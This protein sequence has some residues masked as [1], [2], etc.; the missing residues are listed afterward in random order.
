MVAGVRTERSPLERPADTGR[1]NQPPP[2]LRRS[3]E[4]LG[5]KAEGLRYVGP[6]PS[7]F[8]MAPVYNLLL[9]LRH[10]PVS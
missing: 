9:D 4:A 1:P 10:R 8:S 6:V 7:V 5:A 3:A 2:R